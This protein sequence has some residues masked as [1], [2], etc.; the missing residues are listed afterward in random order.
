MP[1]TPARLT[2]SHAK[3]ALTA[4]FGLTLVFAALPD[5][6]RAQSSAAQT[7]AYEA[8][9][10]P[11]AIFTPTTDRVDLTIDYEIWDFAL[12]NLVISMGPSLRQKPASK[13]FTQGERGSRVRSGHSSRFRNEGSML[14]FSLL[15]QNAIKSFIEYRED[16][17]RVADQIDITRLPRNEQLA[18]WFNL[19]NVMMV[20][21]IALNWPFR[22]PRTLLIDG[23]PLDEAKVATIRGVAMSPRDIRERIVYTHWRDPRVIYGFWRGEIGGPALRR[24]AFTAENIDRLLTQEA[25][26]Y[27]NSMRATEKRGDTLHVAT[28]Y[29]EVSAFYFPNFEQD[30]R[31]HIEDYAT[32]KVLGFLGR[33]TRVE[34]SIREWDIADMSGGRRDSIALTNAGA[35][36]GTG[37]AELLRQRAIK[38]QR[39]RRRMKK[40]ERTGRVYFTPLV[41]PGDDPAAADIQ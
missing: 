2:L 11:F 31:A 17:E 1:I 20:E 28:L 29:E 39:L 6:A 16:L 36:L 37:A 10:D 22:Q 19:H 32:G 5:T 40:G 25:E 13:T 4:L 15:D 23:V 27:V 35:G 3:T 9:T 38:I 41:L 30:I 33:T 8:E 18:F 7:L 24:D 34:A 21:Q 14:A 26:Y 12:K